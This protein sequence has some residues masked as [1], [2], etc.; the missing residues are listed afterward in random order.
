MVNLVLV[1]FVAIAA[2][3]LLVFVVARVVGARRQQASTGRVGMAVTILPGNSL[4]W[5]SAG[6]A[7]GF[8]G[9]LLAVTTIPG[10]DL[11]DAGSDQALATVLKIV[12]VSMAGVSFVA[13]LLSLIRRKESSVLV[14]AGMLVTLWLGLIGLV[15]HLFM[16]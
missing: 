11:L 15:A 9:A 5:W 3:A 14:L 13:G 10:H 6:L 7:I 12:L 2:V 4:G 8:V 1:A 16:E